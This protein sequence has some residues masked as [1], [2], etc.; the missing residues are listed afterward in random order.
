[1]YVL[2]LCTGNSCRSQMAAAYLRAMRPHWCVESGGVYPERAVM[3]NSLA[4]CAERGWPVPQERP[5]AWAPEGR[6]QPDAVWAFSKPAEE[7][8]RRRRPEWFEGPQVRVLVSLV[9]DPI[10]KGMEAYR[11]SADALVGRVGDWLESP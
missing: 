11:H 10:G 6:R 4:L 8:L 9:S 3:P 1:M 5:K 2:M 7:A